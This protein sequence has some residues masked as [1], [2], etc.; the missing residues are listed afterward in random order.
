M[1]Q[2]TINNFSHYKTMVTN[3]GCDLSD[4]IDTTDPQELEK[5]CNEDEMSAQIYITMLEDLLTEGK[6][7]VGVNLGSIY[8]KGYRQLMET[9]KDTGIVFVVLT[10]CN[11]YRIN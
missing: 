5:A 2:E 11:N 9:L 8:D 6:V 10:F 4:E 7:H 3:T 1:I